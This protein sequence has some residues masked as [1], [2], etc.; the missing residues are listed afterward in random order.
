MQISSQWLPRKFRKK[1]LGCMRI[2]LAWQKI[3]PTLDPRIEIITQKKIK[4]YLHILVIRCALLIFFL[5]FFF[6]NQIR[7]LALKDISEKLFRIVVQ[8]QLSIYNCLII[9][10][11]ISLALL[12]KR[13][14]IG[15]HVTVTFNWEKSFIGPS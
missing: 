9:V 12:R 7:N 11:L 3:G 15:T 8:V 10:Y 5:N 14:D 4:D 2:F 6:A 13:F 1:P